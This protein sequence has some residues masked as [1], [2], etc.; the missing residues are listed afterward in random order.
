VDELADSASLVHD[1]GGLRRRLA[2][3]GYLFFRGLLPASEIRTAGQAV[4]ARLRSGRWVDDRGIPLV[5]PHAVNS[6]D[7]LADPAFRAAIASADFNCL[8]Y[9]LP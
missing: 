6:M 7:A 5:Q 1:P 4:L 3:D 9:L 2:D 8:P